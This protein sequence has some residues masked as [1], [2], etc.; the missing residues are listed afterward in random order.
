MTGPNPLVRRLGCASSYIVQVWYFDRLLNKLRYYTTLTGIIEI[1][2]ER[3]LDDHSEARVNFLPQKGDDC[4]GKLKPIFD[5]Q[6]N[7]LEP[8]LWPWAHEIAIYRDG[9][10]VWQGPVFSVDEVVMP[11]ESTD[12]IQITA[13]DVLA[14]LDRR[15]VHSD[16]FMNDQFYDLSLIAERIIRDAFAPDDPGILQYLTIRLSGRKGR[17]TVRHWE[18]RCGDELRTI[19]Q[20]G[21]DFTAIGRTIIVG[22]PTRN[23]A[24]PTITLRARDFLAGI[25]IRIVGAEAATA[26]IAVGGAPTTTDP[27]IDPADIPPNKQYY[28]GSDPYFGLIENWTQS[29]G[30]GDNDFLLWIAKQKVAEGNPPPLTLSIP[31]DSS[32]NPEAPVSIHDLV[33]STYFTVLIAGTCRTLAQYMRLSHVRVAWEPGAEE[34]VGVTFI[35]QNV[36]VGE[37]EDT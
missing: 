34:T 7:L 20:G 3:T 31:A 37:V 22:S 8:G 32:L 30:V 15:T 27:S 6:G 5:S 11:D 1:N 17:H 29:E 28:G 36:L 12:H 23:P 14:W 13:R 35:P 24:V 9:E 25:E 16:I 10:L 2:W 21:L 26:G 19:A 33:P 4:C 18:A